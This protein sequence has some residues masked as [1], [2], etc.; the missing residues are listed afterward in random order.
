[1]SADKESS[2]VDELIQRLREQG[3][4]E[5]QSQADELLEQTRRRAEQRL[6]DARREAE[7]IV[8]KAREEAR[9]T[10]E[11]GEEAVRLAVRDAILTLKSELAEHFADRVRRLV[12]RELQDQGFLQ[13]LIREVAGRAAP[14]ADASARILLPKDY[15]GLEELRRHPEEAKGGTLSSFVVTI[16]KEILREGVEVGA[17]SDV[18]AGIRIALKD[19]DLEIDLTDKAV[20]DLLLRH[21]APRFRALMEGIIQ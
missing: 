11:A 9:Q 19:E 1:M 21:L 16:T 13:Q 18:D 17:A 20:T 15:V 7:D 14:P 6:D 8:A 2:G 4:A 10:R 3:V 12:T 5:G